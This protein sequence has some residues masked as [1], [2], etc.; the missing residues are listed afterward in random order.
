MKSADIRRGYQ[1]NCISVIRQAFLTALIFRQKRVGYNTKNPPV[2]HQLTNFLPFFCLLQ[3]ACIDALFI[4]QRDRIRISWMKRGT[5]LPGAAFIAAN[6][7]RSLADAEQFRDAFGS[8]RAYGDLDSLLADPAVDA[9]YIAT[10]NSIHLAQALKAV[11]SGKAILT[12]KPI[13][14]S[15][16]EASVIQREATRIKVFAM[17]AMETRFLPAVVAAKAKIDAGEIGAIRRITAELAH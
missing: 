3:T 1:A 6:Y 7:S 15:H 11:R 5:K 12:E 13:A 8:K 14:P 9:V 10:P 2:Q 4:I 16:T 17:E